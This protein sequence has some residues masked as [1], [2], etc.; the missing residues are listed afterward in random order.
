M[1]AQIV[2]SKKASERTDEYYGVVGTCVKTEAGATNCDFGLMSR[3][4]GVSYSTLIQT[5]D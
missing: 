1:S 2:V 5:G 4:S 3:F